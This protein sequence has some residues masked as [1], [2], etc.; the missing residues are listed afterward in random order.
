MRKWMRILL[1]AGLF[2][3][4]LGTSALAVETGMQ[5]VKAET[6]YSLAPKT[7]DSQ[8]VTPGMG[9]GATFHKDAVRVELTVKNTPDNEYLVFMLE[10]GETPTAAPTETNIVYIDQKSGTG[11]SVVF[12]L[13]PSRLTVGK[14]Y[15]IYV[16]STNKGLAMA[17]S[18]VYETADDY[19][20]YTPGDVTGDGNVYADDALQTLK[21]AVGTETPT[22]TQALAANVDGDEKVTATDALKILKVAVGLDSL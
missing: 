11:S 15:N 6:G 21:F 17:G 13:Y 5:G 19:K 1:L 9:N 12:D 2:A 4:L 7:A 18:F 22:A 3:V 20:A 8:T 10:E 16:S 14:T